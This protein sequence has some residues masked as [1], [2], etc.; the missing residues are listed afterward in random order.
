MSLGNT[1]IISTHTSKSKPLDSTQSLLVIQA[2]KADTGKTD[3]KGEKIKAYHPN[4][5]ET[6][7]VSVP[8]V[9]DD[10]I[11]D[12]AINLIPHIRN[13]VMDAKKELVK[14][15]ILSD[16]ITSVHDDQISMTAVIAYLDSNAAGNRMTTELVSA[17]FTEYYGEAALKFVSR[18]LGGNIAD[19]SDAHKA[20]AEKYVNALRGIFEL[21]AS[22]K[23]KP[24]TNQFS[25]VLN[26]AKF[27]EIV[28]GND[29]RMDSIVDRSV[30]AKEQCDALDNVFGE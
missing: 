26:F 22:P 20:M 10:L 4:L 8:T 12:S 16:A 19:M 18:K 3:E 25:A 9:S 1:H 21:F 30:K 15:L 7:S 28:E 5:T 2:K 17:W 29:V 11:I 6:V 14:E 27:A 24:Q 13:L 23:F